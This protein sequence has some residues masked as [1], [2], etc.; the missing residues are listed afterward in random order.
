MN[1]LIILFVF[2]TLQFVN[3]ADP[4]AEKPEFYTRVIN[5]SGN[6]VTTFKMEPLTIS[7]CKDNYSN[8]FLCN[9]CDDTPVSIVEGVHD[10]ENYG[11]EG[12][13][14]SGVLLQMELDFRII[15]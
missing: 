14:D 2:F 1:Y 11:F 13:W 5:V 9:N 8:F 3:A 4:T 7:Y 15:G 10:G 6:E 12:C